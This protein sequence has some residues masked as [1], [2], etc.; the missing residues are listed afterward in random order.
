MTEL[1]FEADGEVLGGTETQ[2]VGNLEKCAVIY[3]NLRYLSA[4]IDQLKKKEIPYKVLGG[5]KLLKKH[6][7]FVNHILRVIES[8]NAYS[9]RKVA[10]YAHID[11]VEGGKRKKSRFYASPIGEENLAIRAMQSP[12]LRDIICRV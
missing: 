1:F 11:I 2:H 10:D 8:D 9:I 3:N 4:L 5:R 7:R 6:I 12:T